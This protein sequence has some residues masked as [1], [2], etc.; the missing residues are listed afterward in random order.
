MIKLLLVILCLFGFLAGLYFFLRYLALIYL[1]KNK[2]SQ[3]AMKIDR[4]ILVGLIITLGL[5]LII[6]VGVW[7][8]LNQYAIF[9]S[10]VSLAISYI[11]AL[12]S[13]VIIERMV[14]NTKYDKFLPK[15]HN[16]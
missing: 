11:I 7:N 2:T 6:G 12:A 13:V 16:K 1:K 14:K 3:L 5:L 8:F 10:M 4:Y 9:P 15:K